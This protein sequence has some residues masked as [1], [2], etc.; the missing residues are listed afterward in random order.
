MA[1]TGTG[2][3]RSDQD[4]H[5]N[6]IWSPVKNT[7]VGIEYIYGSRETEANQKGVSNRFQASAQ[8]LF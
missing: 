2:A 7:N 3:N 8:Y 5:T 1:I 6:L 4:I